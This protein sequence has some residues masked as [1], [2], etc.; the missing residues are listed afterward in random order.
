MKKWF[1]NLRVSQKLMLISVFFIMPDS[2]MLY[3]FITGINENIRF[4]RMEKKGDEYPRPT[5]K[6]IWW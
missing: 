1:K 5:T 3:L 6:W 2:L 4:A